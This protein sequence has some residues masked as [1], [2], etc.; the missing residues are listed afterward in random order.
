MKAL[1]SREAVRRRR[2]ESSAAFILPAVTLCRLHFEQSAR[3][4]GILVVE[5]GVPE[6]K[7]VNEHIAHDQAIL[8]IAQTATRARRED[9]LIALLRQCGR[10]VQSGPFAGM[11]LPDQGL[12]GDGN[13][14]PR[15]LGCYEA[16]LHLVIDEMIATSPDLVVSIGTGD[17]YYPVGL[18]R[19]L[20]GAF[21]HA[22]DVDPKSQ[23]ICRQTAALNNV[24]RRVSVTGQCTSDLL[25]AIVPRGRSPVLICDAEGQERELL[26]PRRVPAL[27]M[28]TLVVE[29][30]DFIDASITQTLVDRLSASHAL[31]GVREGPRDPNLSPMLQGLDSLD[32]WL[33]VCE[34]R[35]ATMHWL[36]AKPNLSQTAQQ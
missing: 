20:P 27:R 33:A 14:L 19:R 25:Q 7:I 29:C 30:H 15:L 8:R 22:F 10:E 23:D 21:V 4:S 34:Y 32:R 36:V 9:L 31:T 16:E 3:Q 12:G 1:Q 13:M 11:A 2:G 24:S 6:V 28:A 17:G 26:D 18:A 35:P 5:Y